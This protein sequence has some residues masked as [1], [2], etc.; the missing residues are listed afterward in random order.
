M[1]AVIETGGKQYRVAAGD[2]VEVERLPGDV[3][4]QVTLDRVLVVSA[5][6]S[7]RVGQPLVAGASVR[8]T[9]LGPVQGPKVR[10][11]KYKPK[12]HYRK[13][14]GHRQQYTRLRIEDIQVA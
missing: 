1:Y 8:A 13:G 5:D 9:V 10:I 12:K 14:A 2:T 11:Y 7:V 3:G 4:Q 6:D